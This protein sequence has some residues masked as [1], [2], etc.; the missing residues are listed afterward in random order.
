MKKLVV[1]IAMT[2]GGGGQILKSFYHEAN[3]G[4]DAYTFIVH[5]RMAQPSTATMH[6]KTIRA[7]RHLMRYFY[8]LIY[9]P[10]YILVHDIDE[11]L[12]LDNLAIFT[13]GKPLTLYLQQALPFYD[14]SKYDVSA[15]MRL[16]ISLLRRRILKGIRRANTVIVQTEA[17]RDQLVSHHG[18]SSSK[19]EV[20][21]PK[22][23]EYAVDS[24]VITPRDKVTQWIY[25]S[26]AYFYKNHAMIVNALEMI[27]QHDSIGARIKFTLPDD[28]TS[29]IEPLRSV[30]HEENLPIDF[31]G[32]LTH[33]EVFQAYCEGGLIFASSIESC[34][35]PLLEARALNRPII[36][37]DTDTTREVLA[38]Y[39]YVRYFKNESELVEILMVFSNTLN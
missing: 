36:A 16:K 2:A 27:Y 37:L 24:L 6:V 19:F 32:K 18:I 5:E 30:V 13:W 26:D 23:Q 11:V 22:I 9:I 4:Q 8:Y 25:P 38:G 12:V 1:G 39:P 28:S 34:G 33:E 21:S 31:V 14:T 17:F 7:T 35:L 20:V 29:G 15:K 10:I 3:D